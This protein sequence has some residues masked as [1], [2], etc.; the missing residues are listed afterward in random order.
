VLLRAP[1]QDELEAALATIIA[2]DVAD[3]GEPD[4]TLQDLREQWADAEFN[5]AYD[6]RVAVETTGR[7]LA[8]AHVDHHGAMVSIPPEHEG[9][10]IGTQL[11]AWTQA[12]ERQLGRP[13]HGQPVAS[14]NTTAADFLAA[15]GYRRI[16]S[17]Y[18]MVR[19]LD[20]T[21]RPPAELPD[22]ITLRRI[23]R[24]RDV[25][26]L[27]SVDREAFEGASD[28]KPETVAAFRQRHLDL[29]DFD[30]EASFVAC[31]GERIAGFLLGRR[32][33]AEEA[34]FVNVLAVHPGEHRRGTGTAMLRAAF[35]VWAQA[36]LSEARLGVSSENPGALRLYERLGMIV[37]FQVDIWQRDA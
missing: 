22:G 6:A 3:F 21:D 1:T 31:R 14:T 10:G 7:I 19:A 17:Y 5:R 23:E 15:A 28:Y 29:Y 27:H 34:G 35:A 25:V 32:W 2:R 16:R 13:Y 20:G 24:N 9:R 37:R 36:G 11:L 33:E 26:A 12:R 4:Y 8:Y 18:R 30:P